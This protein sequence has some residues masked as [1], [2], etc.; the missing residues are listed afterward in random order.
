MRSS[1]TVDLRVFS[2]V[3]LADATSGFSPLFLIG[4]GACVHLHELP[5]R[6]SYTYERN[7][8][9]NAAPMPL[10]ALH[11]TAQCCRAA[12]SCETR[13]MCTDNPHSVLGLG[14]GGFGKVFRAMVHLTPVAIK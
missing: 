2:A 13:Q 8:H 3:D 11:C 12:P 6:N 4:E 7:A 5:A 9:A 10:K 1:A 14:I